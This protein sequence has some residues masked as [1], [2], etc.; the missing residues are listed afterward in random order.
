L[1]NPVKEGFSPGH[2]VAAFEAVG[3]VF[4]AQIDSPRQDCTAR[5]CKGIDIISLQEL[6]ENKSR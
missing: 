1:L 4:Q 6:L 5:G 2:E 3:A